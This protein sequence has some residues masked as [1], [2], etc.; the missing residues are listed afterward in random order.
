MFTETGKQKVDELGE[1]GD[2][3]EAQEE[4]GGC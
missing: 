2:E 3:N 4:C 1:E